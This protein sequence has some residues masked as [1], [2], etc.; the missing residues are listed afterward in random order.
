VTPAVFDLTIFLILFL[1]TVIACW[2]GLIRELF[3]IVGLGA[4]ALGAW[5]GGRFLVPV[6]NDWL[7][8]T[9][10]GGEK[11]AETVSK[12]TN[13]DAASQ[14]AIDAAHAK[15]ELILGIISPSLFAKLCAY[16]SAFLIVFL[17]MS[18]ISFFISRSVQEMGLGVVDKLAGAVFGL[19]RGFLL[20]FLPYL[21]CFAVAGKTTEKFPEWATNSTSLPILENI[22]AYADERVDIGKFV[23]DHG[24]ELVLKFD[25]KA[26][27]KADKAADKA[28][29][30]A[31]D[32]IND[33]EKD[34]KDEIAREDAE[35]SAAP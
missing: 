28:I 13:A 22:Y 21:V 5:K 7:G 32:K 26:F 4:S 35:R 2:R 3:T 30:R 9:Q 31:G 29:E 20:I 18:L 15:A 11:A 14:T 34:L 8:V 19:A 1:S 27:E 23:E 16:G 10:D 25:K 17:L 12:G 24:S 6:F 33:A